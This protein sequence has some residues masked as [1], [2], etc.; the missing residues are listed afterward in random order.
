VDRFPEADR[1]I[2]QVRDGAVNYTWDRDPARDRARRANPDRC[3]TAVL[4]DIRRLRPSVDHL[5]VLPHWGFEFVNVPPFGCTVE[6]R[7]FIDA[8]ADLV[9][10]I[11]PHAVQ[12]FQC[13]DRGTVFFSLGN[14]LFDHRRRRPRPG[15]VL[16]CDLGGSR[17]G[18]HR[19][20]FTVQDSACRIS[21]A[22]PDVE[23]AMRGVVDS[24][25]RLIASDGRE[26]SLDDDRV[27]A[28]FERQYRRR[29][30]SGVGDQLFLSL[31][32]PFV[33]LVVL[34]KVRALVA[35]LGRRLRGERTRW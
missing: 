3:N 5:V 8:G 26:Q 30:W 10:G 21:P 12:G 34:R 27:Y 13:H 17:H 22:P 7:A 11:H 32:H 19:F 18:Q 16:T 25:S 14:F 33:A 23:A 29:K 4:S 28:S 35:L 15:A 24:S 6:G 9:V 20:D 31:R 2:A 1:F